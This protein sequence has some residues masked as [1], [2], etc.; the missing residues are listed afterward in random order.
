[1]DLVTHKYSSNKKKPGKTKAFFICVVIASF[2]WLIHALNTV[3]TYNIKI[4]V[5]FNNLPENKKPLVEMPKQ[6]SLDVKASGLKL[7]LILLNKPFTPVRVDFNTLAAINRNQNYILS[8]SHLDF[9]KTFR[10][11]TQIKHISPDTL[12]FSEKTGYQKI[13]P[14]KV[15]LFLKCAEGFGYKAPHIN[16]AYTTIWGDTTI[17]KTIDTIYT[18]ALTFNGVNQTINSNL[19]II[20]PGKDVHTMLNSVNVI[21]DVDKLVEQ[22]ITLPISEFQALHGNNIAIFPSKVNVRYTS[23]QNAFNVA[24]T[25]LFTAVINPSKIN[26]ATKKCLVYLT[27]LPANVTVM[28]IEPKEVEFLILKK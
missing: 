15:P 28:S 12:Y 2:L 16:P 25:G 13:V 4:P 14:I 23:L 17:I 8:S 7:C 24:D 5:V 11:E 3:Y 20:K 6:L 19:S 1:L 18:Q 10:F 27:R 21:I 26:L 22:T 9:K